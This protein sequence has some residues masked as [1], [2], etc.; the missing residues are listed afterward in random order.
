M[1]FEVFEHTGLRCTVFEHIQCIL[2]ASSVTRG[3]DVDLTA[4]VGGIGI[5]Y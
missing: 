3:V 2:A 1:C 5:Y 4:Y